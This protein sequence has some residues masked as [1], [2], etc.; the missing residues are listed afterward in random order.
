MPVPA[1]AMRVRRSG[2]LASVRERGYSET[3]FGR[4]CW[5]PRIK[6][7]NQAERQGSERAAINAPI[8][9]TSADLIKRAM[10]RM[11]AALADAGLS[12]VKMLLQVHDELLFEVD[13]DVAS[14]LA[15]RAK[16][17]MEG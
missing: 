3:L 7:G 2:E 11:P 14:T 8:Q 17:V 1:S 6:S 16:A 5:F 10:A 9:G 15:A 12:D 4:K 13:E